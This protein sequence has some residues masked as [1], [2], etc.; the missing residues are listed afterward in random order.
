[1]F[2]EM[3]PFRWIGRR[4]KD[5]GTDLSSVFRLKYQHFKELLDANTQL[6]RIITD[7][8]QKLRGGTA[9]RNVLRAFPIRPGR[10]SAPFA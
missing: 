6:S 8:E 10:F 3:N 4:P 2:R 9:L 5:P 7:M 1:M